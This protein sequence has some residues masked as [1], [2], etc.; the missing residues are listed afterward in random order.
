VKPPDIPTEYDAHVIEQQADILYAEADRAVVAMMII[1]GIVGVLV[2][3]ASFNF[4]AEH[5][6]VLAIVLALGIPLAA[7]LGGAMIGDGRAFR[8]R[9]QAQQLLVLVAIEK[10]TRRPAAQPQQTSA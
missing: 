5:S 9:S 1:V 8:L 4:V 6:E 2:A 7:A 3:A 10:N